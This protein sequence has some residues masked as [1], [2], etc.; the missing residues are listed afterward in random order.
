MNSDVLYLSRC[1]MLAG[2]LSELLLQH[3]CV[4]LPGF[5]GLLAQSRPALMD[6]EQNKIY[7]PS[8]K[9]SFNSKLTVNDGLLASYLGQKQGISYAES[10][11]KVMEWVDEIQKAINTGS[12][13]MI[14]G[15]GSFFLNYEKKIQFT[16]QTENLYLLSS[17]GLKPVSVIQ[18]GK[19]GIAIPAQSFRK[20]QEVK[21]MG[22]LVAATLVVLLLSVYMFPRFEWQLASLTG[23]WSEWKARV[24]QS[25]PERENRKS[26]TLPVVHKGTA[27]DQTLILPEKTVT[28]NSSPEANAEAPVPAGESTETEE[29]LTKA[30]IP[31]DLSF[32]LIAGCFRI[33]ENAEKLQRRLHEAGLN[34][35]IAGKTNSG[36]TMVSA[37]AFSSAEEA[38]EFLHENRALLT[39]GGWI[40]RQRAGAP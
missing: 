12:R 26:G 10:C 2:Y 23:V 28:Q 11:R 15:V 6:P 20:N 36:L 37:G 31:T 27:T 30:N 19:T 5:G 4:I 34:A 29:T 16:P 14:P 32:L 21:S 7:P 3:D 1:N 38:M 8:R 39:E 24:L 33:E 25:A 13:Y 9:L 35:F 17:Y 18:S 22:M 40:Y